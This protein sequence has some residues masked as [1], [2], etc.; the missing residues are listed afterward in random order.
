MHRVRERDLRDGDLDVVGRAHRQL[1]ARGAVLGGG[2]EQLRQP[3][4]AQVRVH[5]LERDGG[6]GGIEAEHLLRGRVRIDDATV[7]A[8]DEHEVGRLLADRPTAAP[9]PARQGRGPSV[10]RCTEPSRRGVP[11]LVPNMRTVGARSTSD[12]A[13]GPENA[14]LEVQVLVRGRAWFS[15]RSTARRSRWSGCTPRRPTLAEHVVAGHVR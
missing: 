13:V 2:G 9:R 14:V 6:P 7:G 5:L 12:D 11:L 8:G 1:T 10:L 4:A 15:A 3:L